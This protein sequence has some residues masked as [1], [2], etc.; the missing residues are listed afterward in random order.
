MSLANPPRLREGD[1]AL[2]RHLK[3]FGEPPA[4]T[5]AHRRALLTRVQQRLG[6]NRSPRL[7]V[8][9]AAAALLA[10]GVLWSARTSAPPALLMSVVSAAS[11]A[12]LVEGT[13][14]HEASSRGAHAFSSVSA[15]DDAP[16]V[17]SAG[18][19][20]LVVLPNGE[21][22]R[23]AALRLERGTLAAQTTSALVVLVGDREVRLRGA[24]AMSVVSGRVRVTVFEGAAEVLGAGTREQ[25][26][27]GASW[28]VG[29]AAVEGASML[30]LFRPPLG[31][32]E[33]KGEGVVTVDGV[34]LGA[35][36]V[37]TA[38]ATGRHVFA[39]QGVEQSAVVE[40]GEV[41]AVTLRRPHAVLEAARSEADPQRALALYGQVTRGSS[42]EVALY[43]RALLQHRLGDDAEALASLER[44]LEQFPEGVL[45][46]ETALTRAEVLLSL[47]R[48]ADAIDALSTFV[49]DHPTSERLPE[50]HL[51]RGDLLREAGRCAEAMGDLSVARRDVRWADEAS[52]S[53]AACAVEPRAALQQ[54]LVSF[55]AG[56]HAVEARRALGREKF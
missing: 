56:A 17:L 47:G 34:S 55:P 22:R 5:P 9:V 31:R 54:Y 41:V 46:S 38:L 19:A 3:D 13:T 35:A 43:E 18:G 51:L 11:S 27:A 40:A 28:P 53:M 15:G 14:L 26:H 7:L 4:E 37:S 50:V 42:A 48:R 29:A 16:L 52:W 12:K 23:E 30:A 33:V 45:I 49:A 6:S 20:T 24:A 44:A 39:A 36:P 25:V 1:T 10:L 8:A 21:L 2:G 32:V